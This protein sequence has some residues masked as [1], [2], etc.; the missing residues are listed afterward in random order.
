ML[1]QCSPLGFGGAVP[2]VMVRVVFPLNIRFNIDNNCWVLMWKLLI[3]EITNDYPAA[4][5]RPV[6]Y[7]ITMVAMVTIKRTL[8]LP[9]SKVQLHKL[10]MTNLPLHHASYWGQQ[11]MLSAA[12]ISRYSRRLT[13]DSQ[14]NSRRC[15]SGTGY[16]LQRS[17][18]QSFPHLIR[19][20]LDMA[21]TLH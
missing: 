6:G 1:V 15:W 21:Q 10:Q 17:H 19:L 2:W 8:P 13:V 5:R 18:W 3:L 4:F 14:W 16:Q 12:T 20:D 9:A 11:T 7:S